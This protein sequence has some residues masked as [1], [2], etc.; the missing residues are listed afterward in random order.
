MIDFEESSDFTKNQDFYFMECPTT[1]GILR[2]IVKFV[3]E[4]IPSEF[5]Y[6]SDQIQ[7]LS[8]QKSTEVGV[9][10]LNTTLQR[11]LNPSNPGFMH[12]STLY[13]LGDR[14]M[15]IK[16]NYEKGVFNGEI[17]KIVNISP[18]SRSLEVLYDGVK[19]RRVEYSGY[20]LEELTLAYAS[21]IHKSQGNE[22]P[23]VVIPVTMAHSFMLQ[24]NL[25]YTA[26]TRAKKLCIF[27][28]TREALFTAINNIRPS[29]RNSRLK[30]K[31]QT[32]IRDEKK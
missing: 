4:L 7:V 15:H 32:L 13:R 30:E 22:Y 11:V 31:L 9:D 23:V 19:S 24:R 28:G 25:I 14:V 8:P 6:L 26:L 27:V 29:M 10:N 2:S 18:T 5:H 16:N 12:G 20:D 1:F 21:T 3:T 17:G